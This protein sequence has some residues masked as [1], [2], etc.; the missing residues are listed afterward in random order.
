[1]TEYNFTRF[2]YYWAA[3]EL[4]LGINMEHRREN[5]AS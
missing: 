3:H 1:M 4:I 5:I 2:M